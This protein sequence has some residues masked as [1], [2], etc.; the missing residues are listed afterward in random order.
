MIVLSLPIK[1]EILIRHDQVWDVPVYL[2]VPLSKI[3]LVEA[4][5]NAINTCV[6]TSIVRMGNRDVSTY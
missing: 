4:K 5:R 6:W 1:T 2:S 3:S